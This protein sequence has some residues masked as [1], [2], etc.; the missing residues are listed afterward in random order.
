MILL[1]IT[2]VFVLI[3]FSIVVLWVFISLLFIWTDTMYNS[4]GDIITAARIVLLDGDNISFDA[5][6]V[7]T[8]SSSI[9]PTLVINRM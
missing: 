6:L 2:F 5:S 7:S 1:Y 3:S 9:P 4:V 8:N